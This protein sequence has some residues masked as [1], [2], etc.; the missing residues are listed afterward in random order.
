[1]MFDFDLLLVNHLNFLPVCRFSG[2][3]VGG[4]LFPWQSQSNEI[5]RSVRTEIC[6][7]SELRNTL[8][9]NSHFL[10]ASVDHGQVDP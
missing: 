3:P 1:M 2:Y 9:N 4:F 7:T 10:S 8:R 5:P 6:A